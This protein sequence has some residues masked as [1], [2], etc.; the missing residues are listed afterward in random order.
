M[1]AKKP[2]MEI[3]IAGGDTAT[4]M[5]LRKRIE[6]VD[7]A[8]EGF[9]GKKII[10]CGCGG[11]E[12]VR[13]LATCGAD[14]WGIE[15]SREK[16]ENA[17]LS[18]RKINRVHV[19]DIQKIAFGNGEFD[20]ALVNEVL[21]HVPDDKMGLGEVY[22]ILKPGGLLIVFSPNRLYPFETHGVYFRGSHRKLP[23]YTPF[24]PYIPVPVGRFVFDYWAR[25]YWPWELG[26]LIE[27]AGF[28]VRRRDTIWQTFENISGN[29]PGIVGILRTPLRLLSAVLERIPIVQV[30]GVSQVI[31]AEKE[32]GKWQ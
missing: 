15:F 19:G 2:G 26:E 3:G 6:Y 18:G 27:N 13:A 29:Q 17:R 12:Y 31:V 22:R 30:F 4:P 28:I 10:D 7:R 1:R 25:N 20:L 9:V 24:V 11:G 8:A 21:E 16:L 14:S 32:K 23:H 5:N